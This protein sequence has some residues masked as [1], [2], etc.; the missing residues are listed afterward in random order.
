MIENPL[1]AG[2]E[3]SL[4]SHTITKNAT[5]FTG[6]ELKEGEQREGQRVPLVDNQV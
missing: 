2:A 1:N 3:S 5:F 6:S 4:S